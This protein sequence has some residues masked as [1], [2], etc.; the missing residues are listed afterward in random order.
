MKRLTAYLL[1]AS[2]LFLGWNAIMATP[3][4][5]PK[6]FGPEWTK[7]KDDDQLYRHKMEIDVIRRTTWDNTGYTIPLENHKIH[8]SETDENRGVNV[9]IIAPKGEN[10]WDIELEIRE[11]VKGK[12]SEI[13][14]YTQRVINY[15]LD[16]DGMIDAYYDKRGGKDKAMIVFEERFV[17]V[18][19]FK[20]IFGHEPNKYPEVWGVGRKV[21]YIFDGGIWKIKK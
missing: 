14:L 15:D 9:H 13:T 1:C 21:R 12:V 10:N 11:N 3:E 7:D 20:S 19:I 8:I 4:P 17:E 16:G 18:E 2:V 6:K 5:P